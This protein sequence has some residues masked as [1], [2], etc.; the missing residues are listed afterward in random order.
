MN[1]N[2]WCA[3]T[4]ACVRAFP[5]SEDDEV[6][7]DEIVKVNNM[8]VDNEF[9]GRDISVS[10]SFFKQ[11]YCVQNPMVCT[12]RWNT[13]FLLALWDQWGEFN[14]NRSELD[15]LVLYYLLCSTL[16]TNGCRSSSTLL[17]IAQF[18]ST[19]KYDGIRC[20]AFRSVVP[21]FISKLLDGYSS[22][23]PF[24]LELEN[25]KSTYPSASG[26]DYCESLKHHKR[27]R[28][29]NMEEVELLMIIKSIGSEAISS[30]IKDYE[31]YK[32]QIGAERDKACEIFQQQVLLKKEV[33]TSTK[34]LYP[35]LDLFVVPLWQEKPNMYVLQASIHVD[36]DIALNDSFEYHD[37]DE[38]EMLAI[39][40]SH[41]IFN[42]YYCFA[43]R[44]ERFRLSSFL[45]VCMDAV[46][47]F[48]ADWILKQVAVHQS[49]FLPPL[50]SDT[51]YFIASDC[52]C[53][54][55]D[56]H[57][58]LWPD[59]EVQPS[60][61]RV[62]WECASA[63]QK[64][65]ATTN[66]DKRNLPA[67]PLLIMLFLCGYPSLKYGTDS[68]ELEEEHPILSQLG[69][70]TRT[71]QLE[72]IPF[73][74]PQNIRLELTVDQ[75]S[76]KATLRLKFGPE[77]EKFKWQDW[78]NAA[79]GLMKGYNEKVKSRLEDEDN[80]QGP[81]ELIKP[82]NLLR[83]MMQL[84]TPHT[85]LPGL[86]G[87]LQV[88]TGW[89]IFDVRICQFEKDQLINAYGPLVDEN[90]EGSEWEKEVVEYREYERRRC[91]VEETLATIARWNRG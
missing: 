9:S 85:E 76:G 40:A 6:D 80:F 84:T 77:V 61:S 38:I 69:D 23:E 86:R 5:G 42:D 21:I 72:L 19:W 78:I 12:L 10:Y 79:L 8:I 18:C 71:G 24:S 68:F 55:N 67:S 15:K 16:T 63:L 46:R 48:M 59:D 87:E 3:D 83:P 49:M 26:S 89:P 2:S 11:Q 36:F 88:W 35:M 27:R 32:F 81:L 65:I 82:A 50:S 58:R 39:S 91:E 73:P 17:S 57:K 7:L 90:F 4:L 31:R 53:D 25:I 74:A 1:S 54:T 52:V 13:A 34:G 14:P 44:N 75:S 60:V 43:S 28:T 56:F 41:E 37:Q 30:M 70:A 66:Y 47:T 51:F 22:L 64:N 33:Y 62:L 29:T 45:G 20:G